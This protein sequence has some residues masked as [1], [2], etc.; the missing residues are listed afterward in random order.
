[1]ISPWLWRSLV[2]GVTRADPTPIR[3]L[4]T[5]HIIGLIRK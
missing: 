3:C 1:M 2:T 4:N 5:H